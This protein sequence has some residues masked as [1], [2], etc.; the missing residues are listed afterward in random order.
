MQNLLDFIIP[1]SKLCGIH[2]IHDLIQDLLVCFGNCPFLLWITQIL[3]DSLTACADGSK[4]AQSRIVCCVG[5]LD[6]SGI[7]FLLKLSAK[8]M[9]FP[10]V[11]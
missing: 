4:F 2:V 7:I 5:T 10:G 6:G 11:Y 1:K 8:V 9:D 3:L